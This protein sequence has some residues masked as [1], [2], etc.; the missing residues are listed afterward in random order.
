MY[1][2]KFINEINFQFEKQKN[3]SLLI[4]PSGSGKTIFMDKIY[5]ELVANK[6]E[7]TY[8]RQNAPLFNYLTVRENYLIL[9]SVH[10]FEENAFLDLLTEFGL[11][12]KIDQKVANLSGGEKQRLKIIFAIVVE[13]EYTILDEPTNSLGMK[14]KE[15]LKKILNEQVNTKKLIIVTH[16]TELISE[17]YNVYNIEEV[18]ADDK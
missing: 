5:N 4:G 1:S 2:N 8:M 7:V 3:I 18:T 9:Q 10:T 16:D 11:L 12:A 13:A 6:S 14:D 15:V 17:N